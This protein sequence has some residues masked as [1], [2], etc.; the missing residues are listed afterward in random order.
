MVP[1][2]TRKLNRAERRQ[3]SRKLQVPLSRKY[4]THVRLADPNTN[5]VRQEVHVMIL[6]S[7]EARKV[8]QE[9]ELLEAVA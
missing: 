4:R 8:R 5:R 2:P 3:L 7:R 6:A 1:E 9:R